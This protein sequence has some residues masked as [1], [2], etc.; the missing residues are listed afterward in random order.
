MGGARAV[1]RSVDPLHQ[2]Q[3]FVT[4]QEEGNGFNFSLNST[5]HGGQVRAHPRMP[6]IVM[7]LS[8]CYQKQIE[9][10]KKPE[11]ETSN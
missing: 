5:Y 6:P 7:M 1:Q 8:E 9:S 4:W 10:K 3:G 11:T 2:L